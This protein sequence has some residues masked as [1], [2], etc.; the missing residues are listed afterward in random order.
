M[1]DVNR[2]VRDDVKAFLAMLEAVGG[3]KIVEMELEEARAS[4]RA[5]HGM[6]DRPARDLAVIRD[7]ACPGPAGPVPL[8][9]YDAR[10]SRVPGPVICFFHGGG[11]VIGEDRKSTRL[12]SSH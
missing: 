4:Y 2:F 8:R 6:A 3:P 1:I 10:E 9:L 7:L 11:F 5:L 12:N